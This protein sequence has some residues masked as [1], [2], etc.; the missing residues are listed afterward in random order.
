MGLA[1]IYVPHVWRRFFDPSSERWFQ[2]S[3]I[4]NDR[5]RY[6]SCVEVNAIA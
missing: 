5:K 1:A 3:S 4:V 6:P 2:Q